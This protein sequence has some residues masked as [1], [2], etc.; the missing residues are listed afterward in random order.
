M[1]D[2]EEPVEPK[3]KILVM[4][5]SGYIGGNVA[6]RFQQEGFEVIGT[7]KVPSDPKPLAVERVVEP[8]ADALAA[9]FLES[10]MTVLDCLGDMEAS[11][12]MLS[13]IAAAG[14]IES[15]KVLVGISSVM[16]WAR[17]SPDADEPEKPL[18]EAE[19][20]KRRPHSSYKD[21]VALEKLVTKSKREGLRTH[22]VRAAR[23]QTERTTIPPSLSHPLHTQPARSEFPS[24]SARAPR[25]QDADPWRPPP[26]YSRASALKPSHVRG[27][28]R[29]A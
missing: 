14:P 8:T 1:A 5:V 29:L 17:T 27:R 26:R 25:P 24:L 13:A 28:S 10:E 21:L 3:K 11:E 12:A 4:G 6:K 23:L 19:Y 2:E 15:P 20:K 22:V 7:L 9:A 16:T 18:T